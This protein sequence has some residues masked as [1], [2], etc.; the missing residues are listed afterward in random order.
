ML[1]SLVLTGMVNYKN[2][3]L[4]APVASAFSEVGL[5][6]ASALIIVAAVIGLISV[7]L[8]MLLSQTRI[9]LNMAKDGLLPPK[10]FAAIHPVYKTPWKSTIL[11]GAIAS[12]VAALTPI[13]KASKMTSIGTLFAFAMICMAVLI[14]RK[15]QP[16]LHRPFKLKYLTLIA[17]LGVVF[18]IMLMFSL[19]HATW[20]RLVI[21]SIIGIIIYFAYGAKHSNLNK[22]KL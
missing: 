15:N 1:V 12:V 13:E 10:Y 20:I 3:D 4:G 7:M 19:D 5:N 17:S 9:F 22:D 18:N 8:V 14:L 2:I 21:W 11:V 16:D 6:W